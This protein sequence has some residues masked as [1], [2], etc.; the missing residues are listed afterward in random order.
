MGKKNKIL[1][2]SSNG[3]AGLYPKWIKACTEIFVSQNNERFYQPF[4]NNPLVSVI[5]ANYNKDQYLPDMLQNIKCE[6]YEY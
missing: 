5:T 3:K 1:Y 6:M 4:M 2:Q